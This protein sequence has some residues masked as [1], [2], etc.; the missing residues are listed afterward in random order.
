MHWIAY[1]EMRGLYAAAHQKAGAA[2]GLSLVVLRDNL[3][4]DGTPR[5]W[6]QGLRTGMPRRQ[7]TRQVPGTALAEYGTADYEPVARA[8][9][10][11][12]AGHSPYVEPLAPHQVF[13]ALPVPGGAAPEREL[14]AL[15]GRCQAAIGDV[16]A[17]A[18]LAANPLVARAAAQTVIPGAPPAVVRPGGEAAFL[19]PLP[20]NALWRAR[21]E[22]LERLTQ[23]GLS[24]VGELQRVPE[25]ELLR[26]FGPAGRELA[27]WARG[28]DLE[29]VRAAW[30]SREVTW[31]Q[32]LSAAAGAEALPA[33]VGRGAR[34][35]AR[36]LQ[37]QNEMCTAVS[38]TLEREGK[39]GPR[40]GH[41]RLPR[42]QQSPFA[43]EQALLGLMRELLEQPP[44][45][46]CLA[47]AAA[48]GGLVPAGWRQLD[49]WGA[50]QRRAEE[51]AERLEIALAALRARFP[52]QAARVGVAPQAVPRREA[53]YRYYDPYRWAV[54]G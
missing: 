29:P 25:G 6:A 36:R 51:R 7:A 21:P 33:L 19:A 43:L 40:S 15:L 23:L 22:L 4:W 31:R 38:L 18:G 2:A 46:H 48:A 28:E 35:L 42:R 16:L 45:L 1:I 44:V 17:L 39:A 53:M 11:A 3:V 41:R 8:F 52:I 24:R 49:L 37:Q 27:R 9:W 5:A 54:P 14:A 26:Q 47:V 34:E 12:C 50:E 10:N 13:V 30:P 32:A 20:M